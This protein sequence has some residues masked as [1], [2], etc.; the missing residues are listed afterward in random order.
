MA[1]KK[2]VVAPEKPRLSYLLEFPKAME[3]FSRGMMHSEDSGKYEKHGW[4]EGCDVTES[5]DSAM[6]HIMSYNNCEDI[7]PETGV[8]NLALAMVNLAFIIENVDRVEIDNRDWEHN[9]VS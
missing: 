2:K 3:Q 9:E 7:D 1:R 8:N 5:L 6:R 4:K